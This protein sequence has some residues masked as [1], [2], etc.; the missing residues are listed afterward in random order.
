MPALRL[1]RD[2]EPFEARENVALR[3]TLERLTLG[4]H[5]RGRAFVLLPSESEA[6]YEVLAHRVFSHSQ[7]EQVEA[8]V[9]ELD[10]RNRRRRLV[11]QE[12]RLVLL[13][14]IMRQHADLPEW[15]DFSIERLH[16]AMRAQ[17]SEARFRLSLC[18][19]VLVAFL[20]IDFLPTQ[21]RELLRLAG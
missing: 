4:T 20:T 13:M 8:V 19:A 11:W 5:E 15:I 18:R 17:G 1:V 9:H 21:P 3:R 16:T 7:L 14:K 12:H 10:R 2:G 6:L